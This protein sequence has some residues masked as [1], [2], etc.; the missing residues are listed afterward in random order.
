MRVL[1]NNGGFISYDGQTASFCPIV[2][3]KTGAELEYDE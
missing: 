2:S 1:G 3:L